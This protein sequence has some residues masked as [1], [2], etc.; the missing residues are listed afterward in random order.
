[1]TTTIKSFP[2]LTNEEFFRICEVREQVFVLEQKI[3]LCA[4]LDEQDLH[5][6]H[7]TMAD[8]GKI[9]AYA[10][11]FADDGVAHI[12][13][14]LTTVRGKGY[15]RDIMLSA[16]QVC[17]ERLGCR[18]IVVHAQQQVIPFY[19]KLGFRV[20]SALFDECGILHRTMEWE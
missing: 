11:C 9:L 17:R 7:I 10:R 8:G 16:M 1:M 15:G 3:T 20:T 19:E 14:V 12:G 13:R 5:S 4:E 6:I 18:R 2:E